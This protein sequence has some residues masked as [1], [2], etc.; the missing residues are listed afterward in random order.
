[1]VGCGSFDCNVGGLQGFGILGIEDGTTSL[2]A[3][4]WKI[5]DQMIDPPI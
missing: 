5:D 1:M 4:Q 3:L 2:T